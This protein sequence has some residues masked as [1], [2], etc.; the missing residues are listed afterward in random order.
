MD[1]LYRLW[2]LALET[3]SYEDFVKKSSEILQ[4][5]QPKKTYLETSSFD[6]THEKRKIIGE[7]TSLKSVLTLSKTVAKTNIP[8]LLLGET[9]SGKEL[10]ARYIH[11]NSE[12]LSKAFIRI[13]CAAIAPGI[14]DSELFGHEKGAFTGA[15]KSRKGCFEMAHEG[16]LFMDEVG[17]LSLDA[18]ARLLRVLNDGFISRVGSEKNIKVDVRILAAT[19]RNLKEMVRA[20]SFREDLYYRIVSFPISIPSLRERKEDIAE[21]AKHYI[22]QSSLKFNI[23][24]PILDDKSLLK[25]T[26]YDWPGNIREFIAVIE[27]AVLLSDRGLLNLNFFL[28]EVHRNESKNV[29]HFKDAFSKKVKGIS[30]SKK[31]LEALE[32]SHGR[33]EGPFGAAKILEMNPS[34]LRSHIKKLNIV[35]KKVA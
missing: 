21:L 10:V 22:A 31:I 11:E 19:H 24:V 4:D 3:E 17:E 30:N 15:V 35:F 34:T 12:R 13:N 18:Q 25:L 26:S 7:E 27:R 29:M 33:I 14:I 9:G 28:A 16:T 23:K 20:G 1:N 8:V 32:I 6:S 5:F 2:K